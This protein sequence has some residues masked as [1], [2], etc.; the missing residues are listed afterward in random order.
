MCIFDILEPDVMIKIIDIRL[1]ELEKELLLVENTL[2]EFNDF[3]NHSD[4][5]WDPFLRELT[6]GYPN[7][8]YSVEKN[9]TDIAVKGDNII[10]IRKIINESWDILNSNYSDYYSTNINNPRWY[11]V[12]NFANE[13]CSMHI[14]YNNYLK[15][16]GIRKISH[17]CYAIKYLTSHYH[18]IKNNK[19]YE[20]IFV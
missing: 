18:G 17:E 7:L 8:L 19:Y 11:D 15:F 2:F 9:L 13:C 12:Y 20:L 1:D 5:Y 16:A 6:I 10:F 14:I 4:V 3:L